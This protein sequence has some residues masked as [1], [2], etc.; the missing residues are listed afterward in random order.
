MTSDLHLVYFGDLLLDWA[1]SRK[2][3]DE[4]LEILT[5]ETFMNYEDLVFMIY[6]IDE[7]YKCHF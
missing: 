1:F 4:E 5:S 2:K 6:I 7:G 3:V